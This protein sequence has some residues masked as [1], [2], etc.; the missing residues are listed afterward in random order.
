MV[1][2]RRVLAGL[3]VLAAG[4]LLSGCDLQGHVD[5]ISPDEVSLDLLVSEEGLDCGALTSSGTLTFEPGPDVDGSASCHITGT[6]PLSSLGFDELR[7]GEIGEYWSFTGTLSDVLG[8][9][10]DVIIDVRFPGEV[11][12]A[13]QGTIQGNTLRLN[14][15]QF[16]TNEVHVVARNRPGPASWVVAGAAG[17]AA[18]VVLTLVV[19]GL[20]RRA[21][22]AREAPDEGPGSAVAPA[23]GP[24]L[25]PPAEPAAEAPAPA[26]QPVAEPV[27]YHAWFAT[28]PEPPADTPDQPSDAEESRD[29]S[30]WAPPEEAP[31]DGR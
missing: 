5:V 14:P 7:T 4:V 21:R 29:H 8:N 13:N 22:R 25:A 6:M 10:P 30:M 27:I 2:W 23:D 19:V 12:E 3:G 17:V 16:T 31:P 1:G 15:S 28:P 26:G 9:W 18:G 11:V 20:L 24:G